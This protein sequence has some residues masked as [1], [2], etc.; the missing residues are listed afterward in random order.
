MHR[1]THSIANS[2]G[3]WAPIANVRLVIEKTS[4]ETLVATCVKDLKPIGPTLLEGLV[5]EFRPK[6]DIRVL[7]IN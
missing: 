7:F 4:V 3:W 5:R 1:L 2:P 6:D